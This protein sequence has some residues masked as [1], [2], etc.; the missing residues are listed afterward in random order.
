M[1]LFNPLTKPVLPFA[2]A[3][4][5]AVSPRP[6]LSSRSADV[7]F[8]GGISEDEKQ[9][10]KRMQQEAEEQRAAM[11]VVLQFAYPV[12]NNRVHP[13]T[14][15][16]VK[17]AIQA[18][19]DLTPAVLE[20]WGADETRLLNRLAG[21]SR[22]GEA[23]IAARIV[24]EQIDALAPGTGLSVE[25]VAT[26]LSF[27]ATLG[28]DGAVV[29]QALED[30]QRFYDYALKNHRAYGIDLKK[31]T[32]EEV[33]DLIRAQAATILKGLILT[34]FVTVVN[35]FDQKE[36][37]FERFLDKTIPKILANPELTALLYEF[38]H[39]EKRSSI[40][41]SQYVKIV[42]AA[43]AL[44]GAQ[45][46]K[47]LK[48]SIETM[49]RND[50][51]DLDLL[52]QGMVQEFARAAGMPE[53]EIAAFT[54]AQYDLWDARHLATLFAAIDEI[55]RNDDTYH[56]PDLEGLKDLFRATMRG[57]Y[58]DYL[59]DH[60]TAVGQ[61][62]IQTRDAF[63]QARLDYDIWMDYPPK[64]PTRFQMSDGNSYGVHLWP[65]QPGQDLFQGSFGVSCS[66]LDCV[67]GQSV[68]EA[69]QGTVFQF[70]NI[71]NE[72]TGDP[73]AYA[74]C[75]FAHDLEASQ[76]VLMVDAIQ[77]ADKYKVPADDRRLVKGVAEF[78]LAY[79]K[80]VNHGK[81]V[82]VYISSHAHSV[83]ECQFKSDD[84]ARI[85]FRVIGKT[86]NNGYY[87]N[88]VDP[89]LW[90]SNLDQNFSAQFIKV[91]NSVLKAK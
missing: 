50:R 4:R 67:K 59:Y 39:P 90:T 19:A 63:H 38:T 53:K 2:S 36:T 54:Q 80:A 82:P 56:P 37:K 44:V 48:S 52:K 18:S 76:P 23:D 51:F 1:V 45:G 28:K 12:R 81:A 21:G 8:S 78:M 20:A 61:A 25:T 15:A 75:Y 40:A 69:L 3:A 49:I 11:P 34:G 57:T 85:R 70:V 41:P 29:R 71:V 35:K 79:G 77:Y 60:N 86:H 73:V 84:Y 91:G 27:A 6:A 22:R 58:R 66:A 87:L 33:R 88:A 10:F 5:T 55:K 89:S 62:N 65:R 46:L 7:F 14:M 17:T 9:H 47:I 68:I 43:P 16:E 26:A 13:K 42:D 64:R 31:Y 32:E 83:R 74:R 24:Q 72:N 30:Y